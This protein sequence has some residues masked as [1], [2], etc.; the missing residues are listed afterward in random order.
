MPGANVLTADFTGEGACL[1]QTAMDCLPGR[2]IPVENLDTLIPRHTAM[3]NK[4]PQ[5]APNRWLPEWS[6]IAGESWCI[7][8]LQWALLG[9]FG[10]GNYTFSRVNHDVIFERGQGKLFVVGILNRINY[11]NYPELATPEAQN[12]NW[13]HTVCV[14]TDTG[15]F[16]CCNDNPPVRRSVQL[17]LKTKPL[18]Q[19][20]LSAIKKVY[21]LSVP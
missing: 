3:M 6:G 12:G 1:L 4:Q 16:T 13:S 11:L 17:W 10:E 20:Y 9:I 14:D 15:T 5:W 2:A 19:R 21:K 7:K 18:K 8:V